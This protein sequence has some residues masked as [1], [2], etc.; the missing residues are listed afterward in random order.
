MRTI[1]WLFLCLTSVAQAEIS[2]NDKPLS[3][4]N[5]LYNIS[6]DLGQTV[7]NNLFHSFDRFN[8]NQDEI[9]QFSGSEQIQ[10]IISRVIG[11]ES[12]FI[13]GT[14]R[15]TIP[16]AD[17]YFLNPYGV[18]FGAS[19]KLEIQGSFHVSTADYLKL[20]DNGEFHARFPERDLL[21][22]A[23]V[24]HFGFLTDSPAALSFTGS[25]LTTALDQDFF[26][27]GGDVS[28]SQAARLQSSGNLNIQAEQFSLDSS[29]LAIERSQR[30]T[31]TQLTI[32]AQNISIL[33]GSQITTDAINDS[34]GIDIR[35]TATDLILATGLDA[36]GSPV[37]LFSTVGI[38]ENDSSAF[39]DVAL[40]ANNIEF[41]NGAALFTLTKGQ[42]KGGDALFDAKNQVLFTGG[43]NEKEGVS[44]SILLSTESKQA[45]AGPSG[46]AIVNAKQITVDNDAYFYT[47]ADGNGYGGNIRLL[48]E[49]ILVDHGAELV[50][51]TTGLNDGGDIELQAQQV[52]FKQGGAIYSLNYYG[53]AGDSGDVIINASSLLLNR[54][55]FFY[56]TSYGSGNSGN[57]NIEVEDTLTLSEAWE[58]GGG[59]AS[60]IFSSSKPQLTG[61][62]G[63]DSGHID[64]KAR[65]L[66][67]RDGAY[68][69][70]S[71]LAGLGLQAGKGGSITIAVQED[72]DIQGV[73]PFGENESGFASGI[74]SQTI[75]NAEQGGSIKLTANSLNLW[76]GAQLS[77]TTLNQSQGGDI[78][79][80]IETEINI[81]GDA[82]Q[83]PLNSPSNTQIT[84]LDTYTLSP[85]YNQSTSGIYANSES[86]TLDAGAAGNI[87][88]NAQ[89]LKLQQGG[90]ISTTSLGG[91]NAGNINI[92][93]NRLEIDDRA[94]IA[95]ESEFSNAYQFSNAEQRDAAL[96]S[97][98]DVVEVQDIGNGKQGNYINTGDSLVRIQQPIDTVANMDELQQL[99]ERYEFAE[100]DIITVQDAGDGQAASLIYTRF[101]F[102][103]EQSL[104]TWTAFKATSNYV[105]DNTDG[106]NRI[107]GRAYFPYEDIPFEQGDRIHINDMGD[108]KAGDFI[109]VELPFP[110]DSRIFARLVKVSRFSVNDV[111]ELQTLANNNSLQIFLNNYP[112]ATLSDEQ[113]TKQQF[114]YTNQQWV[115]FRNRYTVDSTL[116]MNN[117]SLA[118]V[119][120]Q[121]AL[122][123]ELEQ[124]IYT[125]QDWIQ[126]QSSDQT[127]QNQ[128]GLQQ[129]DAIDGDLVRVLETETGR[130]ESYLYA[131]GQWLRQARGGDAGTI[132]IKA[133]KLQLGHNSAITTEAISG[134]GGAITLDV[135]RLVYLNQS[136]ISTSVQEGLGNGGGL[137]LTEPQFLLMNHAQMIAQADEGQGGNIQIVA[138]QF[139]SSPDSL[140]SASSRLGID[141]NIRIESPDETVS[142][143]LLHLNNNFMK[144]VGIRNSCRAMVAGQVPTEFQLPFTFKANTYRFPNDFIGDW[145]PSSL[146]G[147]QPY[148]CD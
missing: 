12:S 90:T 14:L 48:A 113:G 69:S 142:D 125:G 8:L 22:I 109:F 58:L 24:A 46:D 15:S 32:A 144:K 85:N 31:K 139:L 110:S 131:N 136:Q 138:N 73:N 118:K 105:A 62:Q 10:N 141:G 146:A 116:A 37:R 51:G 79:I 40:T 38:D 59:I 75:G 45:D 36:D 30:A 28:I 89:T 53:S 67:M 112:I 56:V 98:G 39:G 115:P 20:S 3:T 1:M 114:L 57:I 63:G 134:G 122:D 126:L 21:T 74:Y 72:I 27:I 64:I 145:M 119:G 26:I 55:G 100:G 88:L 16:N 120:D 70:V 99:G 137:T 43:R 61:V 50:T 76:D 25:Q 129:F 91:N 9:A 23:P 86:K 54:G 33:N 128:V 132:Q 84:F 80:D 102:E 95:S 94:Q 107:N 87:I 123:A 35:L 6:Q 7:G 68:I 101:Y 96:L 97:Q 111:A 148:S 66:L 103:N 130:P 18:L 17:F 143:G 11:G 140:V 52:A 135:E 77:S 44:T 147:T 71:S 106:L 34:L 104:A 41:S 127:V 78:Q 19:A 92:N 49:Q 133:E 81:S 93:V 65:R 47:G 4:S 5:G 13:N 60:A 83:I 29:I 2:I 42:G 117:L 121:V 108:G 82:S 124:Q